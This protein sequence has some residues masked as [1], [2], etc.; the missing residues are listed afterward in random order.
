VDSNK[1]QIDLSLRR[2]SKDE[3]RKKIEHWKKTRKAETLFTQAAAILNT[4][5]N[6]LYETEGIKITEFYK[7]LYEGLEAAAKKGKKAL[8]DAGLNDEIAVLLSDIAKDKILIKGVTI[9]G[10]MEITTMSERG[11]EEIKETFQATQQ[12][13]VE[14]DAEVNIYSMGAP[15]Y[16]V[17]VTA[18][19][20]KKAEAALDKIVSYSQELWGS[21][22]GTIS[23]SRE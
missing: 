5:V 7:D 21:H 17:E 14:N 3:R 9:Q 16:R 23:F 13:G 20:Y 22:E 6:H 19:D 15:K 18:E 8:K 1:E 12:I 10:I 2:V 11:V 4:D